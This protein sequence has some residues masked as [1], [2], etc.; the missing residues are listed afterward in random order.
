VN[1]ERGNCFPTI[2]QSFY[3]IPQAANQLPLNLI[4]AL[5]LQ[6]KQ[7]ILVVV[8]VELLRTFFLSAL[9]ICS[10]PHY[11][12]MMFLPKGVNLTMGGSVTMVRMI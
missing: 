4:C 10:D 9:H 1:A 6:N 3:R 5:D 8:V 7:Q 2:Y 12:W 11:W